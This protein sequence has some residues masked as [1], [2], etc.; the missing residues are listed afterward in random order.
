[1]PTR[2]PKSCESC[3]SAKAR[4]SLAAPC[5]RC[6]RRNVQCYYT[7]NAARSYE[8]RKLNG[9]RSI[10][11]AAGTLSV[12]ECQTSTTQ[13]TVGATSCV[14]DTAAVALIM[15]VK[16]AQPLD[17]NAELEDTQHQNGW[18]SSVETAVSSSVDDF[19]GGL[20][21]P[22]FLN[23]QSPSW[24]L[25][26]EIPMEYSGLLAPLPIDVSHVIHSLDVPESLAVFS[27]TN[28]SPRTRSLQQGSLTAKMLLS[29][30]TE[31]TR[32]LAD[33]KQLPPFIHP[34]CALGNDDECPPVSRHQCLPETLAICANLTQMF[35]ARLPGSHGF[36]WQQICT[37]VRQ[38]WV[39]YESY[40]EQRMLQ[41]MQAVAVYGMLCS[42]CTEIVSSHDAAWMVD[43]IETFGERLYEMCAW[44][45]D[46]DLIC[47]TRH[48]WLLVESMRR[49]G[50]L[51]YLV[52]LLLQIDGQSPSSGE[53]PEFINMPLPCVRELWQ[54]ITD[55]EWKRR[56]QEERDACKQ[57][58]R[59]G[60][61]FGDLLML[62][63]SSSNMA[64]G[65]EPKE[66]LTDWCERADD[67]S[68]LLWMAL[69]L[70]GE[71]QFM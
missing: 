36:V 39:E 28:L 71:G 15:S 37:H 12:A 57:K 23:A 61:I 7:P 67:L 2:R 52:D 14:S 51:L 17:L 1:M 6:A 44:G 13:A 26:F 59:K 54:P 68:M 18:L 62:K 3:R 53:C 8:H 29:R 50:C 64:T 10:R 55:R 48:E 45:L 42:Q 4:C 69:S 22:S 49:I 70:E 66:E 56:Y 5:S 40:D 60:L 65:F 33:G 43:T 46:I 25:N 38:M 47:T 32:M 27:A 58:G 30:L 19:G 41:A 20:T 35:H 34:P 31:Y 24:L 63:R 9:F 16:N 21:Y 11:P